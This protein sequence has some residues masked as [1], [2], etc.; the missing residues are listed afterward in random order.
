MTYTD[1]YSAVINYQIITKQNS[2]RWSYYLKRSID[3]DVFHTLHYHKLDTG[4][5]PILFVY[6][7]D[8]TFVGFPLLKREIEATEYCDFTST[9][10]YSGPI[11]NKTFNCLTD[12]FINNLNYA[13]LDFMQ[14][15][16]AISVFCRL[17]PFMSQ[18][19]LL[20][21]IGGLKNNG[22]TIYI[23]LTESVETQI[24][25]YNKR[26]SRQIRQL[27][28]YGFVLKEANTDY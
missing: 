22:R 1:H 6:E 7:E 2:E 17:N 26:L 9:Y 16:R 18:S 27:R 24:A 19:I 13:F 3:Y 20:E 5:E 15:N 23:D 21:K 8:E 11:S 14:K 28:R 4:G 25:R 10:G 12:G